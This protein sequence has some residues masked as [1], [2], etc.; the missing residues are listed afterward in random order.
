MAN[1]LTVEISLNF[2]VIKI[3]YIYLDSNVFMT[4][5][6]RLAR[7]FVLQKCRNWLSFIVDVVAVVVDV[8]VAE[9]EM[10]F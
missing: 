6:R 1:I 3:A 9:M 4:I 8:V 10:S 5:A 7:L 2:F